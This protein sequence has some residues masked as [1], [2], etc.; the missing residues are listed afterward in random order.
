MLTPHVFHIGSGPAFAK[1]MS[2]HR[3]KVVK[4]DQAEDRVIV[5][6]RPMVEDDGTVILATSNY[7]D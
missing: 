1:F 3:E 7:K 5:W 2:I 6:T 4:V